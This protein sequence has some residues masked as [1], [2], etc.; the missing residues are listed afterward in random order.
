MTNTILDDEG[1]ECFI[2]YKKTIGSKVCMV[3]YPI[4]HI[5]NSG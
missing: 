4:K 1:K 5:N 3:T 2:G